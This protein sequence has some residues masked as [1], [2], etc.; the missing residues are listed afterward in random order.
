MPDIHHYQ[1]IELLKELHLAQE[2]ITEAAQ[3]LE[4][5]EWYLKQDIYDLQGEISGASSMIGFTEFEVSQIVPKLIME[6]NNIKSYSLPDRILFLVKKL[7]RPLNARQ[8]SSLLKFLMTKLGVRP[9]QDLYGWTQTA[10]S[11]MKR[12]KRIA[13]YRPKGLRQGYYLHPSWIEVDGIP[14]QKYLDRMKLV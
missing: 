11:R 14:F 3:R 13:L 6:L 8:I 5:I 2:E 12:H 7:D 9:P 4:R 10:L 1:R